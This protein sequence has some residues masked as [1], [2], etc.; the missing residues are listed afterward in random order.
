M[1]EEI[2]QYYDK[3][4]AEYDENR[5]GNTYGEYIDRQEKVILHKLLKNTIKDETL[6]MPCGTGRLLNYA[7]YG[8]DISPNML[9][10]AQLKY[11]DS[12]LFEY[13]AL[14]TGF[15]DGQFQT[16]LSFHFVMHLDKDSTKAFFTEAYRVLKPE[17]KLILDFP[18]KHR[19]KLVNYKSDNWHA[20]N[21]LSINNIIEMDNRWIIS[22]YYG[23]LFLPI[24]R[25][26]SNL[27]RFFIH[28]DSFICR[29][30]F[31]HYASYLIV[32]MEKK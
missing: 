23:I 28:L 19:R 11:P 17:G 22:K 30:P 18:S 7:A 14:K 24:H 12:K 2:K 29:S 16:I 10:E 32:E 5:F 26:P 8:A 3:L 20:S 1:K 9:K 27:R 25:F 31:K 13:N 4:A 6:D 21:H 15:E